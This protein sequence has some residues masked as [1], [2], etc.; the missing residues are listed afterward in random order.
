MVS[1]RVG[2]SG[3]ASRLALDPR[4]FIGI[5]LV[6]ASV[7]GVVA[8][9]SGF[10][11]THDVYVAGAPLSP[12]DRVTVDDLM[13][14][15][16]QLEAVG[17]LYL[18]LDALPDDGLVVSRPVGAGELVPLG[19]VTSSVDLDST[20]VVLTVGSELAAS[21]TPGAS[22]DVWSA[23]Q[24]AG[25]TYDPP[26]VIAAEAMVVRLVSEDS[27]VVGGSTTGIE[28]LVPTSSLARVLSAVANSAAISVVPASLASER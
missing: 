10:D 2:G 4:L 21:V 13:V 18:A 1:A 24:V 8:L 17:D 12:G 28:L 23:E 15:S 5:A 7:A 16:V 14:R 20:A 25:G 3:K 9:V 19:S 26:T 27:I 11:K 22:V 6:V